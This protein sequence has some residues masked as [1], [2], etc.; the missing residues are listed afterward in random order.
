MKKR[1]FVFVVTALS[2]FLVNTVSAQTIFDIFPSTN[3]RDPRDYGIDQRIEYHRY[4]RVKQ[5]QENQ[6]EA[7]ILRRLKADDERTKKSGKVK[8]KSKSTCASD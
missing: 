4:R 3:K 5:L 2:L 8:K 6:Q 7:E 1:F